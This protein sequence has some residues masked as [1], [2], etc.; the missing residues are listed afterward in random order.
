MVNPFSS[1]LALSSKNRGGNCVSSSISMACT[2]AARSPIAGAASGRLEYLYLDGMMMVRKE[3]NDDVESGQL[4][5]KDN[6]Q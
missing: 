2:A 1:A 6:Y 5:C 3:E 4:K